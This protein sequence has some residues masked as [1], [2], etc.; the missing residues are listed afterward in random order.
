MKNISIARSHSVLAV[1]TL[2]ALSCTCCAEPVESLQKPLP[3]RTTVL[4]V[5]PIEIRVADLPEPRPEESVSIGSRKVAP[6]ADTTLSAPEGFS[7]NVFAQGI[8]RARW[9]AITPDGDLLCAASQQDTIYLLR[10][11]NSDGVADE[12]HTFLDKSNGANAPFGMT[13]LGDHFYV[14][15]TDAVLRYDYKPG[16]T[17]I[18]SK[19]TKI[20]ELPGGGYHQHWTRNIKV[21]PDGKKLFVTVG[22]RSNNSVEPAP[23]AAV[24]VMNLDGSDRKVFASGLRNPVGLDFHPVTHE[25]YVTVN[26][27]DGIGHDLVPDYFTRIRQD[28]F[29][30]W[31]YVYFKPENIDKRIRPEQRDAAA[32]LIAKTLVP[33]VL[34]QAHSAALGLTFYT[35]DKF[36]QRY[37]NGAFSAFH[38]S[39]NRKPA[40]GYKIVFIPFNKGEPV[41][42]YEDFVTGFLLNEDNAAVWGRPTGVIT[43]P[44]GDLIFTDDMS[45]RIFRVSYTTSKSNPDSKSE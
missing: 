4:E 40:T 3:I 12:I 23:R 2:L 36:P 11:T 20:T 10:D 39:W 14:A 34:F 1:L 19:P 41:G 27:R 18:T 28:E 42:H 16:Q 21:S 6:P 13:F 9:L 7:V 30:G 31:P 35:G 44:N 43:T 8:P 29:F 37:R 26:E 25:A 32:N 22:S 17:S 24:I 38:G 33:D 15:N 5:K 45:G